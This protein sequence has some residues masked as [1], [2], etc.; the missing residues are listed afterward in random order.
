[1]GDSQSVKSAHGGEQ[2]GFDGGK[3][4]HG[5]KR[6]V[7]ADTIGLLW[8]VDVQAANT[9]DSKGIVGAFREALSNLPRL[10]KAY[11]DLGYVG[12]IVHVL[13]EMHVE[14]VLPEH[15]SGSGFVPESQRWVIERTIG[16][17]A[18]FRRLA[19]DYETTVLASANW[20]RL[21]GIRFALSKFTRGDTQWAKS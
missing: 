8:H 13:N 21:A 11:L 3:K 20:I 7:I 18:W 17:L 14:V 6:Q 10:W 19:R 16:W 2:I 5:R 12:T 15:K 4:V 1:M 9:H